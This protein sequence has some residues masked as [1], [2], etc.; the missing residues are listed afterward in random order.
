MKS[1]PKHYRSGITFALVNMAGLGILGIFDKIGA[2]QAAN[3]F[4]FSTQTVFF[5]LFFVSVT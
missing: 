2:T 3:P 5:A 4:V 1:T